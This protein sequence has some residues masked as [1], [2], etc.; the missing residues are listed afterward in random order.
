MRK[1][2]HESIDSIIDFCDLSTG[3]MGIIDDRLV[4]GRFL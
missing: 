3:I 4:T 1:G 2:P